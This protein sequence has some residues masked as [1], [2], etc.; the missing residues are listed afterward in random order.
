MRKL[1]LATTALL[2]LSGAADAGF[3]GSL[4]NNPNSST[5]HFSNSVLGTTF[6]DDWTF[7]L[8]GGPQFVAFASATNDFAGPT[9]FI[10]NFQ[11]QLWSFGPNL[12]YGGG[13]DFAVN[14]AAV[15]HPC[16]DNPDNCQALSGSA[17]LTAG[18]YFLQITGTGGGTAG[19]GGNLTTAVITPVPEASTWAMMILGFLGVGG[20]AM[21]K[22]QFRLV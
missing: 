12:V 18:G 10:T 6:T 19:Y 2:A 20:L 14:P 17:L 5:G 4:G 1:L 13:D 15:S 8:I 21:R 9:D 22:Q 7:Q 16:V 11:G 3:V